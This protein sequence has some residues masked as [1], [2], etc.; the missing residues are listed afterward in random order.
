MSAIAAQPHEVIWA[1]TNSMVTSR[2]LHLVTELGVADHIAEEPVSVAELAQR[3]GADAGALDRLLRL[4]AAHGIFEVD[5]AGYR[6]SDASRLLRSDHPASMRAFTRLMG[7]PLL[8]NS[9]G[10]LGLSARTG[11]PGVNVLEPDGFFAYL[12]AHPAEARIFG[13]AMSSK[14]QADIAAVLKAYDFSPFR[15]IA[16]IG[17]GRGHLLEAVLA[18]APNARGVL[19]DLPDVI[20]TVEIRSDRLMTHPA[21]FFTDPLPAADAYLLMEVIHDWPDAEA[22]ALLQSVRKAAA[23]GA[24]VLI[25]EDVI[26]EDAIDPRV[27]TLDVI[28]LAVTGG[29]ERTASQHNELLR[30]SG[31]RPTA[32]IDTAGPMRIVEGVAV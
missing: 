30:S 12:A 6:H 2:A 23:P 31:F 3:S 13:E 16:D 19:L 8:W 1:I 11:A 5:G 14:A 22:S 27:H 10:E 9:F 20:D 18:S 24:T 32:V 28:M 15:T 17:G 29:R 21:D 4:L 7:L 25:I 26:P